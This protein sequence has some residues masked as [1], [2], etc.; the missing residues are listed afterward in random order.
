MFLLIISDFF[1]TC[2][3]ICVFSILQLSILIRICHPHLD[4]IQ[5]RRFW[6][7]VAEKDL[8]E[9]ALRDGLDN[10][11]VGDAWW[12]CRF[13]WCENLHDEISVDIKKMI[14]REISWI[15]HLPQNHFSSWRVQC[16]WS[17]ASSWFYLSTRL[18]LPSWAFAI[19]LWDRQ[20]WEF[21]YLFCIDVLALWN[22]IFC[23]FR[24][25]QRLH[26][27][28]TKITPNFCVFRKVFP[29]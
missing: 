19:S 13:C 22:L 28:T 17:A 12:I 9:G 24:K 8:T 16:F 18:P 15:F 5:L 23:W 21:N 26:L 6:V 14:E 1:I 2:K 11:E 7:F 3:R 10:R 20:H 29:K 27:Y 4:R 25:F